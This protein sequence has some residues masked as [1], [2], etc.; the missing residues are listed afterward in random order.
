MYQQ[1]P[2]DGYLII[3]F[4]TKKIPSLSAGSLSQLETC[5]KQNKKRTNNFKEKI[6]TDAEN[7]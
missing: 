7:K 2:V 4:I 1:V 6:N 3:N 5:V